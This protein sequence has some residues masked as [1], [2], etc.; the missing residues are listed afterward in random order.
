MSAT[1]QC[2]FQ[3]SSGNQSSSENDNNTIHLDREAPENSVLASTNRRTHI[4]QLDRDIGR[5]NR[6]LNATSYQLLVMIREF[7]ERAGWLRW[8]FTDGVSWLKWR[9]DLSTGAAREKLR[10]THALKTLPLTSQHFATGKLSYSKVRVIT[11]IAT[12][13][14]EADLVNLAQR[15]TVK[16]LTEHCK[17]RSNAKPQS[18]ASARAAHQA[19]S[20]RVWHDEHRGT[21]HL[22]IELPIEEGELIEQAIE[23]AAVQLASESG[24]AYA[25]PDEEPSWSTVQVDAVVN[26][27]RNSLSGTASCDQ[28]NTP[29]SSAEQYQVVVHVDEEALA[30]REATQSDG[31]GESGRDAS[32][33]YP[34]ETVRRLCCDGSIVP[35]VENA[36][37]EPINVGRKV[38]TVTTAMRRALWARDKGCGFPGCSHSR[39]VDAHHIKH[40]AEGGETSVENMVLLCSTHHKLVHEGAFTVNRERSGDL[41]FR[42][43]D[44]K[45]VPA[46][47]FCQEDWTDDDVG[48]KDESAA[49]IN[50]H[51]ID[52][53]NSR[54]FDQDFETTPGESFYSSDEAPDVIAQSHEINEEGA[55]YRLH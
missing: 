27:M 41:L 17:R 4:D 34:I 28:V 15:L 16:H 40:W 37:G 24:T 13:E 29:L 9:C 55:V 23:K 53:E 10:I 30:Q 26:I 22:S 48:I 47:G 43:P 21:M 44:G 18:T 45:A 32:S 52:A 7:D 6:R 39:F 51:T 2:N 5:L 54:E 36:K 42:R 38:R 25:H 33:Q 31:Q 12:T 19:R 20:Y 11:R 14:N 35:I 46:C 3:S 49:T 50:T 1:H 8:S